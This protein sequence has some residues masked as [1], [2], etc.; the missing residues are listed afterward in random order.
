MR[1]TSVVCWIPFRRYLVQTVH[2]PP[3]SLEARMKTALKTKKHL[4]A[5]ATGEEWFITF[6]L[7]SDWCGRIRFN[8][9]PVFSESHDTREA[10]L[11]AHSDMVQLAA[12]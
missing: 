11:A 8:Q 1:Q 10:A 4:D 2:Y 5:V 7:K 3:E 6:T 9:K 12:R